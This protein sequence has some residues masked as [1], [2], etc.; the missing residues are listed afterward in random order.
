M[1]R[2]NCRLKP[3]ATTDAKRTGLSKGNDPVISMITFRDR[4]KTHANKE[5][6]EA[7]TREAGREAGRQGGR[8]KFFKTV[9]L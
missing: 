6:D 4:D 9:E 5:Q 3:Q 1:L 2:P 8:V 7:G